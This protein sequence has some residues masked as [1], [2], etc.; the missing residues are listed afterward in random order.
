MQA[1]L[2]AGSI[3]AVTRVM[4]LA[5]AYGASWLLSPTG[6]G[7]GAFTSMWNRWDAVHFFTIS[8]HGYVAA[9]GDPNRTAFFPLYPLLIRALSELG[10]NP[11]IAGLCISAAASLVAATYLFRLAERASDDSGGRRAVLYLM[12]FPTA[13]F[14]VAPYSEALF[15]AGAIPAF[16]Y[17]KRRQWQFVGIPA[18]VA[19]GT[20]VAGLFLLMG[21]LAEFLAQRDF[22]AGKM[23]RAGAA[24]ALG[25]LPLVAYG[26]YL[27]VIKHDPVHFL[28]AERLGWHRSFTSPITSFVSTWRVFADARLGRF[29]VTNGPRIIW[30]GE[31][32]AALA[33]ILFTVWAVR[34]REWGYA[35]FMG[36]TM[37]VL[38]T[39]G[40]T[41][42]SIPRMLLMLFPIMLFLAEWTRKHPVAHEAVLGVFAPLAVAG[43]LIFT[44]GTAWF[45]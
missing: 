6:E 11:I 34:K 45:Y 13:V 15:L 29:Q 2:Q 5:V 40:T 21:L 30:A 12:L 3:V 31:L 25:A 14:L 10:L 16:Y 17:A 37:A 32:V 20:R 38:L 27:G 18:A 8:R 1:W 35:V 28:T 36:V 42:L 41:Y 39:S 22:S 7:G 23:A 24:L 26:A 44:R 33:G 19:M 43:L 4:F 9:L